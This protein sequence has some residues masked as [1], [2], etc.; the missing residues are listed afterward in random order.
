MQAPPSPN[1]RAFYPCIVKSG[2]QDPNDRY[3]DLETRNLGDKLETSHP[4]PCIMDAKPS[5]SLKATSTLGTGP[6]GPFVTFCYMR[7]AC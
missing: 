5:L 6:V 4:L 3:H 1:M 7:L 2:S